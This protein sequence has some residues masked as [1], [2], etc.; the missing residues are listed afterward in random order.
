M[1]R[2]HSVNE[3]RVKQPRL[4]GQ[5]KRYREGHVLYTH[6]HTHTHVHSGFN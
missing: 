1:Q 4:S 2:G 3:V 6:K 5:L